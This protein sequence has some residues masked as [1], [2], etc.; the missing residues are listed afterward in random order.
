[1]NLLNTNVLSELIRHEPNKR[2]MSWLDSLDATEVAT[3]AITPAELLYGIA[4]LPQGHRKRQLS[5][6]T[7]GRATLTV[8]TFT[9]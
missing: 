1:M 4:R 7:P 6:I 2:V 8:V 5:Q 3:T 9:P